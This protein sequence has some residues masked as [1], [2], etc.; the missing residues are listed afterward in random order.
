MVLD[1]PSLNVDVHDVCGVLKL[2][3]REMPEPLIPFELYGPCIAASG[4]PPEL[5]DQMIANV[6][7]LLPPAN[8]AIL[9]TICHHLKEVAAQAEKNLMHTK[10]L[11]IVFAPNFLR[12]REESIDTMIGDAQYA[13]S[14]TVSLL[15]M[16][17]FYFADYSA[18][19]KPL[20]AK[21]KDNLNS[22]LKE[23]PQKN[24]AAARLGLPAAFV[25]VEKEK[26]RERTKTRGTVD[27]LVGP[28]DP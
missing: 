20:V 7:N 14:L 1:D 4:S 10:N 5:R 13:H 11:A 15:S 28:Y 19:N 16:P 21:D 26:E 6:I 2:Y 17:E 22:S 27:D 8:K 3:L 23:L 12:A 24:K 9:A 18:P 25:E